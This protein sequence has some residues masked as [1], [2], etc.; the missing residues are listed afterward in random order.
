MYD[1]PA[2]ARTGNVKG[3]EHTWSLVPVMLVSYL[4]DD[5]PDAQVPSFNQAQCGNFSQRA[6]AAS[7]FI[8][9]SYGKQRKPLP[10][11]CI[12]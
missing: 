8:E 9:A 5:L 4:F 10:T 3:V 7:A 12:V 11:S 2:V 1:N 6:K